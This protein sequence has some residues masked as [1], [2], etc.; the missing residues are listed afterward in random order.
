MCRA[1]KVNYSQNL[2]TQ[3]ILI[4][5]YYILNVLKTKLQ[6]FIKF[7]KEISKIP[8][9]TELVSYLRVCTI[10]E[11]YH[12]MEVFHYKIKLCI[13]FATYICF[14]NIIMIIYCYC[15]VYI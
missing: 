2:N 4:K 11:K 15:I 7:R 13:G 1:Y 12:M 9:F 10:H 5:F 14:Y 3:T 8:Q 6:N